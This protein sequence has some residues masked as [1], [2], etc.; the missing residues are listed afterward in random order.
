MYEFDEKLVEISR[1]E[2]SP[3]KV[4]FHTEKLFKDLAAVAKANPE[5]IEPVAVAVLGNL[6]YIINGHLRL[7]ALKSA[8]HHSARAHIIPVK[9]IA[10][11]VRLHIEL[12]AHGSINPLRMLDAVRFLKRHHA[13]QTLPKRYLDLAEKKPYPSV[14]DAWDKFLKYAGSKYASVELP[15]YVI[16]RIAEFRLEKEQLTAS[17]VIMDSLK[18]VKERKFV[19]PAPPELELILVS[20]LPKQSEKEVIVFEPGK[21]GKERW[22]RPDKKEAED[23]VR[24]SPHNSM[25]QCRCGKRLLLNTKTRAVSGVTDD[26]KNGCIK[27]E[28]EKEGMPVYAIPQSI[29]EFVEAGGD[30]LR[31]LK[32]RSKKELERFTGTI[33]DDTPLRLVIISP[34]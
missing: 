4:T 27:L 34:R 22:P 30:S 2:P 32:I 29:T 31:F 26:E 10:D 19:F 24:A 15:L 7:K 11:V 14:S 6:Q 3:V 5:R 1:L 16:E 21:T 20:V 28:E 12:N 13:E 18:N 23:L 33:K 9:E 25:V 8:G 17:T